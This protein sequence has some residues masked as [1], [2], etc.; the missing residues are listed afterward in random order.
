M[1]KYQIYKSLLE[2]S[3][4]YGKWYARIVSDETLT[5]EDLCS[6]MI[7]HNAPF[8]KGT[9][10]GILTDAI[11]C[12]HELLL[13]GK[14]VQLN[15]LASFGLS[16][17]HT[18][19]APT[20]NDFSVAKNVKSVK[21][22]AQGIGEFSKSILTSSASL[23]ESPNYVSPRTPAL[24]VPDEPSGGPSEGTQNGNEGP[25]VPS[26]GTQNGNEGPDII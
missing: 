19:G 16:V 4:A 18:F 15:D 26:E 12:I 24:V 17:E 5:L 22:T 6:H 1:L 7:E 3:T 13:D 11:K 25:G 8:S 2:G 21:L 20:A 10:K 23:R 9:I 14:R